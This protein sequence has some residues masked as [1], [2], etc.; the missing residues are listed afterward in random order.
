[1]FYSSF[2]GTPVTK[3]VI[4]V[5]TAASIAVLSME[6]NKAE[7]YKSSLKDTLLGL[8]FS[9]TIFQSFSDLL[10]GTVLMHKYR[11]LEKQMG[12]GK[13]GSF[14][15]FAA[16]L[17]G[18]TIKFFSK[19]FP[20]IKIKEGP[21]PLL[22]AL[23]AYY[24]AYVPELNIFHS[25]PI[26]PEDKKYAHFSDKSGVYLLALH[27]M[28][29]NGLST[30]IPSSFGVA[31]ACLY[32]ASKLPFKKFLLPQFVRK[33]FSLVFYPFIEQTDH[34][35]EARKQMLQRSRRMRRETN[36]NGQNNHPRRETLLGPGETLSSEFEQILRRRNVELPPPPS[37]EALEAIISLGF[38]RQAAVQALRD[39]NN[40][41]DV[42]ASR[43]LGI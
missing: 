5:C 30:F 13:Y 6:P 24:Y 20:N 33:F 37:E 21:F 8:I 1:M 27:M 38:D 3:C 39:S 36:R 12:S 34:A 9:Q 14:I 18:T 11:I 25:T 29:T 32:G 28:A 15:L 22:G 42:A 19:S 41:I 7:L 43:L 23:W 2:K 35:S 26:K 40:N 17:G 16:S 10:C 4:L 31:I